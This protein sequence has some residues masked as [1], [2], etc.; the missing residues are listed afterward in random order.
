MSP[1]DG[2]PF[3]ELA[4][5]RELAD[6]FHACGAEARINPYQFIAFQVPRHHVR[7]TERI[8]MQLFLM[9]L[10]GSA[11]SNTKT[12]WPESEPANVI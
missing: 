8:E 12:Q 7:A 4:T 11:G 3:G 9:P 6:S 2:V 1:P 5:A 10:S